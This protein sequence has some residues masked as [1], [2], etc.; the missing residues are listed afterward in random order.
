MAGVICYERFRTPPS[1]SSNGASI[2][3]SGPAAILT[4]RPFVR[5]SLDGARSQAVGSGLGS[6]SVPPLE[7]QGPHGGQLAASIHARLPAPD[8]TGTGAFLGS[9]AGVASRPARAL[10]ALL[11]RGTDLPDHLF[12]RCSVAIQIWEL[13]AEHLH[14]SHPLPLAAETLA[15][16]RPP[17]SFE[18]VLLYVHL[19]WVSYCGRVR[20]DGPPPTMSLVQWR[21]L[22]GRS[23]R[24]QQYEEP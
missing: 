6:L 20:S 19:V 9:R 5:G 8:P 22:I 23:L 16:G 10:C 21:G 14:I 4:G 7:G 15:L 13:V 1:S 3:L 2:P 24:Y 12:F 18:H 11:G 17:V